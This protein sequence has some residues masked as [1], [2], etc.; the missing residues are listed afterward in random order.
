MAQ[1][2]NHN[3]QKIYDED[4]QITA[5][6]AYQLEGHNAEAVE[7]VTGIPAPTIRRWVKRWEAEGYVPGQTAY[8]DKTVAGFIG[9]AT[10]IRD[11]AL[12][13]MEK[14]VKNAKNLNQLITVV[15][16]LDNKIRIASGQATS[17]VEERKVDASEL[18]AALAKY[19]DSAAQAT[20]ERHEIVVDADVF[21]EQ[22]LG[23]PKSTPTEKE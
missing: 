2:V 17:I 23:L 21:E 22:V 13:Q 15:D 11:M 14:E 6:I 16:K 7:R 9:K 1:E 12:A 10:K 8:V 5:Y 20:I 4:Q 18:S 3:R 19:I